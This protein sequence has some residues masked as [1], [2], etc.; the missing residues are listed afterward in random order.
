MNS[1]F[2]SL[3]QTASSIIA[4]DT[5]QHN[6]LPSQ[7]QAKRILYVKSIVRLLRLC[8]SKYQQLLTT[9]D[10]LKSFHTAIFNL[11]AL[12]NGVVTKGKPIVFES[13][14]VWTKLTCV[15]IYEKNQIENELDGISMM[16]EIVGSIQLQ[17][18][19]TSRWGF[20]K[21]AF[22]NNYLNFCV[23]SFENVRIF[24]EAIAI[25]QS[26]SEIGNVIVSATLNALG[27]CKSFSSNM[28][29]LMETT[30][31]HYFRFLGKKIL[32]SYP[33]LMLKML[34]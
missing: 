10:G 34:R 13:I 21:S 3:L 16:N 25:W 33:F 23:F 26:S 30:V 6:Q 24:V 29:M 18:E 8:G 12:I 17:G 7:L 11:L 14:K 19:F 28:F 1:N 27:S 15:W 2:H 20:S 32:F 9:P 31:F 4:S 22:W 5:E